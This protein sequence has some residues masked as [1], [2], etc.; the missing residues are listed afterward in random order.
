MCKDDENGAAN[1]APK[2][3]NP[4][5]VPF[6]SLTAREA[7][8]ASIRARN[9]RTQMRTQILQAAIDEGIDKLFRK[10]LKGNDTDK[11]AIIEKALKLTGLDFASSEDAVQKV[12]AKTENETKLSGSIEFVLPAKK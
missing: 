11:M 5:G 12:E 10:A 1:G 9:M 4:E 8:K 6:T 2:R 7:Q 3:K